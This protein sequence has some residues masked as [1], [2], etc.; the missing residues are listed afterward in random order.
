MFCV[1]E[2]SVTL[3]VLQKKVKSRIDEVN[4]VEFNVLAIK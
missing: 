4:A 1:S 2:A 3:L